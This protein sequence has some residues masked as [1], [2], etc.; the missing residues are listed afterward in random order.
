MLEDYSLA[1]PKYYQLIHVHIHLNTKIFLPN[2][3]VIYNSFGRGSIDISEL[4]KALK[5]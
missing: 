2:R 4:C 5:L 3:D 1:K